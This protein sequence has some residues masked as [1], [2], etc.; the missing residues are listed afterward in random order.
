MRSSEPPPDNG[1][2]RRLAVALGDLVA[3]RREAVISGNGAELL[4]HVAAD[5]RWEDVV[6]ASLHAGDGEMVGI[7]CL[8]N[9]GKPLATAEQNVLLALAGHASVAL[10]NARLFTRMDQAN[11]HWM[12][13][14]DA[15]SDFIVVHDVQ[16]KVLRINR[17]MVDGVVE[18][19]GGAHPTSCEPD[20]AVASHLLKEYASSAAWWPT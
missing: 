8:A 15:I 18:A 4:G 6:V 13:I 7:L 5:L 19:P 9:R 1:V 16:H 11:R 14:F 17:S 20:Y 2:R 12:E 3:E 10:E